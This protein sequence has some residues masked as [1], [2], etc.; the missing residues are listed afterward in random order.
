[1]MQP[2]PGV[3]SLAVLSGVHSGVRTPIEGETCTI[4]SSPGCDLVL[5]DK[6]V[7]AE[8]LQLR[9]C[10]R[11]LAIDA[12][13]GDVRIE[14]HADLARGFG[15]RVRL[16]VTLSLGEA[17]LRIERDDR[18]TRGLPRWAIYTALALVVV[19]VPIVSLRAAVSDLLPPATEVSKPPVRAEVP[20]PATLSDTQIVD[21][22]RARIATAGLN[23][24]FVS[25]D[26]RSLSVSGALTAVQMPDW[27]AIQRWFDRTHG[28]RYV[29]TSLVSSASVVKA[30]RFTFQA[31]W[32]GESPYVIDGKGERRYPGAALQDGWTLKAIEPGEIVMVRDGEEFRLTL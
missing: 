5:A 14:G 11:V 20:H 4:G 8:H 30:P 16:P 7:V 3:L 17:R 23:G 15:C 9:S 19:M 25:V 28:G 6:N 1:M 29:L 10:G 24:L 32:F 22:L 13:G 26:G 27:Q 2:K 12:V 31:V 18:S 21:A